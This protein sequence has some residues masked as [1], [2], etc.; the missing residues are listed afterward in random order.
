MNGCAPLNNVCVG[1]CV[2]T[3]IVDENDRRHVQNLNRLQELLAQLR[4][5]SSRVF[6]PMTSTPDVGSSLHSAR[7]EERFVSHCHL[8]SPKEWKNPSSKRAGGGLCGSC[9]GGGLAGVHGNVFVAKLPAGTTEQDLRLTFSRVG[10]IRSCTVLNKGHWG[11]CGFVRFASSGDAQAAIAALHGSDGME[12]KLAVRP[13]RRR[14]SQFPS[15][16]EE[17]VDETS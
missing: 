3:G 8:G 4:S 13:P 7:G 10:Q 14:S 9:L 1:G 15:I 2:L 17:V 12:V 6:A 5:S 11:C 16:A